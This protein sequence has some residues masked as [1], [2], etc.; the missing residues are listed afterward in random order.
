[1]GVQ[2]S[3]H[4]PHLSLEL[5][6]DAL[7]ADI[8]PGIVWY[9]LSI[10]WSRYL[11]SGLFSWLLIVLQTRFSDPTQHFT[12]MRILALPTHL[13]INFLN[14][15]FLFMSSFSL[16]TVPGEPNQC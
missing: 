7:N 12:S 4:L 13:K 10:I 1:M 16:L 15:C 3:F 14:L 6:R 11:S 5:R 9:L 8:E 2:A